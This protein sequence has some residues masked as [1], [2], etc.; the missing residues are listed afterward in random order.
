YNFRRSNN[1]IVPSVNS[2]FR[3]NSISYRGA[4]LWNA[5]S[6]H[7]TDQFTVF[8][9]HLILR[10]LILAHSRSSRCPGTTKIL[11]AFNYF[12]ILNAVVNL[13]RGN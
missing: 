1:I 5:V 4:I 7:F 3:K 8:Y 9:R 10:N 2:Q 13:L 6:S 12:S 11:N